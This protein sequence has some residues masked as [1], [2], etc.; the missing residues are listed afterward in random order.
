M[1]KDKVALVTGSARGIG[2]AISSKLI[3]EGCTVVI[4]DILEDEANATAK[5][6]GPKAMA[7]HTNVADE[8]SVKS[9]VKEV[10]DSLGKIDILVN[11]AGITRDRLLMRM[12]NEEWD[13]V[14]FREERQVRV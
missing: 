12:S 2:K 6:F 14:Q 13:M 1:L 9:S 8:D 4:S 5:E 3:E 7:I 11:N 10:I